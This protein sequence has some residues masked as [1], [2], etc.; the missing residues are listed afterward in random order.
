MLSLGAR[1]S[2][3]IYYKYDRKETSPRA[4]DPQARRNVASQRG[5]HTSPAEGLPIET[6]VAISRRNTTTPNS[7]IGVHPP[8]TSSSYTISVRG[9]TTR[10]PQTQNPAAENSNG[11]DGTATREPIRK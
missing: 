10:P 2:E 8:N 5:V 11:G 3:P 4:I 6:T 9:N 1:F 7:D